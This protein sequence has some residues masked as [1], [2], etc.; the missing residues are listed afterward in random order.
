MEI[1]FWE[2]QSYDTKKIKKIENI[3]LHVI[4][5]LL[6]QQKKSLKYRSLYPFSSFSLNSNTSPSSSLDINQYMYIIHHP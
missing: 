4:E 6:P 5:L 3:I 1:N 2:T